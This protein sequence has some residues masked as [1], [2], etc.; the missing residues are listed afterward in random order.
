M[1]ATALG[2]RRHGMEIGLSYASVEFHVAVVQNSSSKHICPIFRKSAVLRAVNSIFWGCPIWADEY[3]SR[4]V[5]L[6]FVSLHLRSFLPRV[7]SQAA[8]M[9][10]RRPRYLPS[11]LSIRKFSTQLDSAVPGKV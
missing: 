10:K 7:L 3:N 4:V 2:G 5:L 6:F 8:Q 9:I 1:Y 11:D